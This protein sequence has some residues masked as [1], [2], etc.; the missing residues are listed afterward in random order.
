MTHPKAEDVAIGGGVVL[1]IALLCFFVFD[2][3]TGKDKFFEAR[4]TRLHFIPD[5]SYWT[6]CTRSSTSCTGSGNTR[7]CRTT[8]TPYPCYKR[9][10]PEHHVYV[11]EQGSGLSFDFNSEH[12]FRQCHEGDTVR[13]RA[14]YGGVTGWRLYNSIDGIIST[15]GKW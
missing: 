9:V 1:V 4:V 15:T 14:R 12:W 2:S 8:Y 10:P 7:S 6:T 13:L 11:L 3:C 5:R